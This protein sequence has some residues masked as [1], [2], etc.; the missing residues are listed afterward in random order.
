MFLSDDFIKTFAPL[1]D[2]IL[3]ELLEKG[4]YRYGNEMF[5]TNYILLDDKLMDVFWLRTCVQNVVLS[6]A[7]KQ[8][9]KN[10]KKFSIHLVGSTITDEVEELYSLY[11]NSVS[12]STSES[13]AYYLHGTEKKQHFNTKQFQI[14]DK[15]KLI[16][17]G[18]FDV[19]NNS[20]AGILNFY[21]PEY[22]KYSLG[23]MLMLNKYMYAKN[24]N[25]KYYYTGYFAV[26]S[27]RFD[28]KFFPDPNAIQ[29]Y[30]PYEEKWFNLKQYDI[31]NEV[32][33]EKKINI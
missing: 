19:G 4:F 12:F 10:A 15:E 20:L 31:L 7:S 30:N 14:R 2:A 28:Y 9:L 33:L 16:A 13:V 25:M 22:K 8:I 29:V 3:D 23:K 18:Y 11:R 27:N 5:T 32:L 24:F 21:N 17:V 26:Q 6:K 1:Q